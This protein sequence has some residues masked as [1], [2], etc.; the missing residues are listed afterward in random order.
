MNVV[1]GDNV[2]VGVDE[3]V[4]IDCG[5]LIDTSSVPNLMVKWYFNGFDLLNG[6]SSNVVISQ[7]KRL[8]IITRTLLSVGGELGNSG[9]YTCEVCSDPTTCMTRSTITDICG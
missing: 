7:D 4:I 9:N 5:P 8:C 2:K 6:T 1:V 3:R